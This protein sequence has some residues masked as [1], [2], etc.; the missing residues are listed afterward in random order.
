MENS[1]KEVNYV[2][3]LRVLDQ[4]STYVE[5]LDGSVRQQESIL[6][7]IKSVSPNNDASEIFGEP[8]SFV[9]V[10]ESVANVVNNEDNSTLNRA[11]DIKGS[12]AVNKP[13]FPSFASMLQ[14]NPHYNKK[15]VK[16]HELRN[17]KIMK[18]DQLAFP[19]VENYVKNTWAK[20]GLKRIQLHENFFMF[21]FNTKEG[22][23]KVMEDGPWL[24]RFKPLFLNIWTPNT[25]LKKDVIKSAPLWVKLHHGRNTYA[26]ALFEFSAD[27]ELKESIVIAIPLTKGNGK[28]HTL[29]T[30]DVEYE[31]TPPRKRMMDLTWLLKRT[32]GRYKNRKSKYKQDER[33][34]F[35]RTALKSFQY[36]R[37][38]KVIHQRITIKQEGYFE[39]RD[40]SESM[41]LTSK[42]QK[43]WD[44]IIL[45]WNHNDVEVM[46]PLLKDDQTIHDSEFV[47][48]RE[49]GGVFVCNRPWC[50]LGDFNA[51]LYLEEST[52]GSSRIDIAMRDFKACVDDIEN[53]DHSPSLLCIPKTAKDKPKPFKFYN[54]ITKHD[55]FKEIVQNVWITEINGFHM[56]R[57]VK[58]LKLMKKP[59]RKLLFDKG[60]LHSNV[61]RLR[62]ELD[63]TG[64]FKFVHTIDKSVKGQI[65]RSRIDVVMNGDGVLFA[66]DNVP[67]VFVSHYEEFLGKRG[68]RQGDPLSPYLFTLVME[69]LTLMLQR[70]V[71]ETGSFSYHRYCDK[72]ELINLCFAD[73]LFLFAY[74]D[75]QSASIIKRALDEVNKL[76]VYPESL[77]KSTAYFGNVLN[78]IKLSILRRSEAETSYPTRW[79]G[80]VL[81]PLNVF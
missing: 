14:R 66:N 32:Q 51:T 23:E 38:D 69:V 7:S 80:D 39:Q 33:I 76:S 68:L 18:G 67:N 26:R 12:G 30:I 71:M 16:I 56:F 27:E 57:V 1:S 70:R 72:L 21:Q 55:K 47:K 65:S 17:P 11:D 62:N 36:R 9:N 34:R 41:L 4:T 19:L 44:R 43:L 8:S 10:A 64:D 20:Y 45:G 15:T 29:A 24:I 6:N 42:H 75:V 2:L 78:H 59:L 5:S 3:S 61:S 49:E 50:L 54:I 46:D 81:L 37:V 63:Q 40:S 53:S 77:P 52:A 13:P 79:E 74:G 73:D 31:W 25:D 35:T 28:G 48:K 58:R 22:M 60:N